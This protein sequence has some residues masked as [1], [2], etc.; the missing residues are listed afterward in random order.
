MVPVEVPLS[1]VPIQPAEKQARAAY[2]S[3][4]EQVGD[5]PLSVDARFE[6]AEMLAQRDEVEPA[7]ALLNDAL[8]KE[9]P[10]DLTEKVRL[11][12]GSIQGAK[13][14]MKAALAQFEAVAAN[15]KS[16]LVGWANYRAGEVYLQN[17]QYGEAVKRLVPFR[18]NGQFN[19]IPGLSDRAL[20]RLGHAYASVK[21]WPESQQAMERLIGQFGGSPWV[22]E[23]KYGRAWARQQVNDL[24]G[25][26]AGYNEVANRSATELAARSQYQIGSCKMRQKKW[27]EAANAFLVVPTTFDYPELSRRVAARSGP[28]VPRARPARDQAT[29]LLQR[30]VRE[31]AN[32]PFAD[33][34]KEQLE[35]K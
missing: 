13:G 18:D 22:D 34:A 21:A 32:S 29:R 3:L 9:P 2:K 8:D 31:Y 27:N 23:A 12:I 24:D 6:L 16:P 20:L 26:I 35:E 28:G 25:A 19:N 1:M 5:V 17:K 4:I 7:L 30:I 14:N 11:R 15:P 33:L 10:Q